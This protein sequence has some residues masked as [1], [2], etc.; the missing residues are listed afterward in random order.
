MAEKVIG[1]FVGAEI[2][3]HGAYLPVMGGTTIA[4]GFGL[5]G[6]KAMR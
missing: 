5:L 2:P 4:D 6:K 1:P 3:T